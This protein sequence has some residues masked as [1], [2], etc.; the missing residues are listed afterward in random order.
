MREP[1]QAL[2]PKVQTMWRFSR[3]IRFALT[4]IVFSVAL[5]FGVSWFANEA[6]GLPKMPIWLGTT[7]FYVFF[8]LI[9]AIVWPMYEYRYY[10]YGIN[11]DHLLVQ[12]G[13]LFRRWSAIPH[14]RIQHVDTQQGP[15]ERIFGL[16]SLQ[17][18]TASGQ[19]AD[20]SIPGLAQD[21]AE[22][23]R[24]DLSRRRGDDGV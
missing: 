1:E 19:S 22:Q 12:R 11:D 6:F 7:A 8:R 14:H 2:D 4:G 21:T 3:L 24:D 5:G 10:R 16:A 23:L 15:I 9:H 13:V 18:Y 17:L 20:G